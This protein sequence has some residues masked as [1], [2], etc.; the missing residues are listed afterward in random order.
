MGTLRTLFAIAVVFAHS[1]GN[2]LVG[3]QNAVQLFY[4]IS[5]FLISYVLVERR[6]YPRVVSFYI[7]RYLRLYPIYFVV[8]IFT[9]AAFA[10]DFCNYREVSFFE[11]YSKAPCAA[12][13]FMAVSNVT[14]LFQDWVM[15][16]GV[17][18]NRLVFA[19]DFMRSEVVLYPALLVPQAWTLGVELTFYFLAP[20]ILFKKRIIIT[21]LVASAL[22]RVYLI[23]IGLGARDPWTYRFFPTELALFLFGALAH[24]VLLPLYKKKFSKIHIEIYSKRATYF[25]IAITLVF[26]FI[27]VGEILKTT[28]LFIL[29]LLLM[30]LTFIFQSSREWDKWIGNLSYPI[31]INHMFVIYVAKLLVGKIS[32]ADKLI[33]MGKFVSIDRLIIGFGATIFSIGLAIILNN[34]VGNP[35]ESL[36]NR[37]RATC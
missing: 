23:C 15:F 4:M 6:T 12:N 33:I 24:Q 11:V 30:P 17:E 16:A 13:I 22:L 25:L 1:L 10:I 5:G 36:R 29:F 18:G 20:Y 21:L 35:V 26:S 37:F 34:F 7:N 31:Y 19:T 3:G 2:L 14:L 32:V 27:P 8:A 28:A 9:F